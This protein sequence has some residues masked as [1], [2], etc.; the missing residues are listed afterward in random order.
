MKK[1]KWIIGFVIAALLLVVIFMSGFIQ[2]FTRSFSQA[3]SGS[4]DKT[5]AKSFRAGFVFRCKGS[6][7]SPVK[8]SFCECCADE[9]IAQLTVKQLQDVSF[10]K[11]YIK[12]NIVPGCVDR[13]RVK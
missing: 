10:A 5:F 8:Q 3:Y 12:G 13:S 1:T 9:A 2:G 4:Y 11:E 6:D 7:L